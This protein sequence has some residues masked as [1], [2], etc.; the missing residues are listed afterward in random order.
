MPR[1]QRNR[2]CKV[3]R[4]SASH[5]LDWLSDNHPCSRLHGHN[6]RFE[7]ILEGEC[8]PNKAWIYDFG[9]L[10]KTVRERVLT[11]LDH[12]HLNDI[13]GLEHPTAE[14]LAYW[15]LD[16]IHGGLP[17]VTVRVWETDNC[18]AEAWTGGHVNQNIGKLYNWTG[19]GII[20]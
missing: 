12:R 15:I 16:Q 18:Y 2:I 20:T 1:F 14:N 8:D 7:V 11:I 6:Y 13:V 19:N 17:K 4:F 10:S 3:F 9:E 5:Q